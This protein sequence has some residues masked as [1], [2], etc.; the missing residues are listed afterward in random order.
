MILN[1]AS[2]MVDSDIPEQSLGKQ[3]M[4]AARQFQYWK[5]HKTAYG[6]PGH[7]KRW[8]AA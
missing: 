3:P 7:V 6:Y 2:T 8:A 1:F 4:P 5:G